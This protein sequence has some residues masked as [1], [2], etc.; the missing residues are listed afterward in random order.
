MNDQLLD[1]II[2]DYERLLGIIANNLNKLKS[3]RRGEEIESPVG[4]SIKEKIESKRRE[5]M[6][7][8]ESARNMTVNRSK[9]KDG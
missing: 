4:N 6:K 9:K 5:I 3:I 7:Q 1:E 8:V 2:E